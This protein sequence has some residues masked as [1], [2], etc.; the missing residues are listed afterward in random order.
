MSATPRS[1]LL[2]AFLAAG[3]SIAILLQVQ[4][5]SLWQMLSAATTSSSSQTIVKTAGPCQYTALACDMNAPAGTD[6]GYG[7]VN[8]RACQ[9][10]NGNPCRNAPGKC[11]D[12]VCI[13]TQQDVSTASSIPTGQAPTCG[14]KVGLFVLITGR[15]CGG[16]CAPG[17]SCDTRNGA[18]G[19]YDNTPYVPPTP[20][21]SSTSS[22]RPPSTSTAYTSASSNRGIVTNY[23]CGWSGARK[24]QCG[25]TCP[26]GSTCGTS[27]YD[28]QGPNTLE[29]TLCV[30]KS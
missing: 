4:T 14:W 6:L 17:Q 16:T 13:F 1:A 21:K 23:T 20:I 30:C 15:Y 24:D 2:I 9:V 7:G 11:Q 5:Q 26:A 25:G 19:C 3:S 27:K 22:G 8:Q 12:G 29:N 28:Q 10:K 18:C